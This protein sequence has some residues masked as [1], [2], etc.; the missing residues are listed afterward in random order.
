MTNYQK[1]WLGELQLFNGGESSL[2]VVNYRETSFVEAQI[3]YINLQSKTQKAA[4]A[5]WYAS[6]QL[7]KLVQSI[8]E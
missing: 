1:L 7:P 4:I 5:L 2:F 8:A 3:K 6:G